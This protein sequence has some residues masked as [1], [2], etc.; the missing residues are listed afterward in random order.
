[1]VKCGDSEGKRKIKSES[2]M[3]RM[4]RS[5]SRIKMRTVQCA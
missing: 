5:K 2:K 3:R 1:M 4:R